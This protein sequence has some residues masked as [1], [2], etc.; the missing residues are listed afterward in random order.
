MSSCCAAQ[1]STLSPLPVRATPPTVFG[2][3]VVKVSLA[4]IPATTR[5]Q[6]VTC[7]P[8]GHQ[9][10]FSGRYCGMVWRVACLGTV[11]CGC[12]LELEC[13][14]NC[15]RYT[16]AVVV[17]EVCGLV[18]NGFAAELP[19]ALI[20]ALSGDHACSTSVLSRWRT[21]ATVAMSTQPGPTSS[22]FCVFPAVAEQTCVH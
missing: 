2:K 8:P 3:G 17:R 9:H 16:L 13:C 15:S 22:A 21:L 20:S 10:V 18:G 19:F 14:D 7:S 11:S 1:W 5:E 12:L 6:L 4:S